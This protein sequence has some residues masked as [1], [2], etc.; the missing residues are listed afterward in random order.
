M[1]KIEEPKPKPTPL[2]TSAFA[3]KKTQQ[4]DLAP[5]M[6]GGEG[7]LLGGNLDSKK[8]ADLDTINEVNRPSISALLDDLE[9]DQDYKVE[10]KPKEE[11]TIEELAWEDDDE[12]E[13]QKPDNIFRGFWGEETDQ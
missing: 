7:T 5:L 8:A 10:E 4:I 12:M 9:E 6:R 1:P 3:R 11:I 13:D 2:E